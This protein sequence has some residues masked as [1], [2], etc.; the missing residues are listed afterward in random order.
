[1]PPLIVTRRVEFA[2]TDMAGIVHFA[3]FYRWMEEAEHEYFRAQ[4][5]N[6][7]ERQS[8]GTY[9]GWP[10]VNA[11][12]HFEAPAHHDDI[13][14]L[15][16]YV[17]RIGFKSLTFYVEFHTGGRRIA[18]GRM[19]TACCICYPEGSLKS[20]EIPARYRDRIQECPP[21]RGS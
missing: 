16:V 3:N 17:E 21:Q 19:K 13:L 7:M 18:Y 1:M 8:D 4:G 6:I 11:S 9:I 12:C 5:L 14:D 15:H 20:I 2:Q 10:R